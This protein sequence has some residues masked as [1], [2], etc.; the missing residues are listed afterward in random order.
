MRVFQLVKYI[1][2]V[3]PDVKIWEQIQIVERVRSCSDV[4]K[5]HIAELIEGKEVD[6]QFGYA[7]E[8]KT[9]EI[10]NLTVG[11]LI[12]NFGFSVLQAL[13][14][15]DWMSKEP[16]AALNFLK[17]HDTI[18]SEFSTEGDNES[19]NDIILDEEL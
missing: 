14:I 17:T 1:N 2:K 4:V 5:E 12:N 19:C 6:I 7:I 8:G 16:K 15:I 18:Q 13:F 10:V 9:G 3:Y 11:T